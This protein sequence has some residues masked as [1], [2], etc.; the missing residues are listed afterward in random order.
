M[1]QVASLPISV[2]PSP[3][4]RI[5][6]GPLII[7][8][9][10]GFSAR[11]DEGAYSPLNEQ[12][13]TLRFFLEKKYFFKK[14]CLGRGS[15][16]ILSG[17]HGRVPPRLRSLCSA[18]YKAIGLPEHFWTNTHPKTAHQKSSSRRACT[19]EIGSEATPISSCIS[20]LIGSQ[21]CCRSA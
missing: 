7:Y 18:L 2:F 9:I 4:C 20:D 14:M 10:P 17:G 21:E 3:L 19:E 13:P 11:V 12:C 16:Y 5:S 15:T 6:P 1:A 8:T